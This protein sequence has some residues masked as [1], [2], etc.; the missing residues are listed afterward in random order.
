MLMGDRLSNGQP[1]ARSS[2]PV[3]PALVGSPEPI[4]DKGQV[5]WGN[6][7]ARINDTNADPIIDFTLR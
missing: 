6:P 3:R 5:F 2:F 1:Q 7:N 4:K